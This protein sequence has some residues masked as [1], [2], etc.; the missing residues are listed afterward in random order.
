MEP[1]DPRWWIEN[2]AQLWRAMASTPASWWQLGLW[3]AWNAGVSFF[4]I[5]SDYFT[6]AAILTRWRRALPLT[7]ETAAA[8]VVGAGAQGFVLFWIGLAGGLRE[9]VPPALLV[10][11][12]AGGALLVGRKRA[13]RAWASLRAPGWGWWAALVLLAPA[14]IHLCDLTTPVIEFD[15]ILYHM[16]AARHYLE[17]G[18]LAYNGALRYNAHPQWN[19]LLLLRQW[20]ATSADWTAKFANLEWIVVLYAVALYAA[21]AAT[22]RRGWLAGAF[23]VLSSPILW[24]IAKV[25]YA[26]LAL[27]ACSAVATAMLFHHLKRSGTPLAP[28]GFVLGCA[29]ST[30]LVGHVVAATMAL[31]FLLVSAARQR[32]VRRAAAQALSLGL[33]AVALC[34]GWWFRSWIYTGSPAY[35]F[36][37]PNHPDVAQLFANDAGY[38]LG[39]TWLDFALIPW[40]MLTGPPQAFADAFTF[41]PAGALL[42]VVAVA[43]IVAVRRAPP[44]EIAFLGIFILLYTVIWFRTSQ[45]MRY[46][47]SLLPAGAMALVW[48]LAQFRQRKLPAGACVVLCGW[49]A[50][51]SSVLASTMR[52]HGIPPVASSQ[53]R[54]EVLAAALPYYEAI[55]E[56]NRR[57][58]PGDQA[59]LLFCEDY[60]YFAKPFAAGDWFGDYTYAWLESRIGSAADIPKVLREAGFRFIVVSR[61]RAAL[62]APGFGKGLAESA[63]V[64]AEAD[65]PGAVSIYSSPHTAVF[66]L[67]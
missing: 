1:F 41:G 28:A 10:A 49:F 6:G 19:V 32:S 45:V 50:L 29:A 43:A 14:L 54:H 25:E 12:G 39:R 63:F 61:T 30:K 20:T 11:L 34:G 8:V 17:T 56:L 37:V 13:R 52:R 36:F 4:V 47:L 23:F 60:K 48:A 2:T 55:R 26:D 7:L 35:P 58:A 40:R 3:L 65:L 44:A 42:A 18:S 66:Q 5:A 53:Q 38:G 31:A 16:R 46:L 22:W 15:S 67:W 62:A 33:P 64:S 24:W 27:A 21:R 51:Y 57:A 9:W 59:Y